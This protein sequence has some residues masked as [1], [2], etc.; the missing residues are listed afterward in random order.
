MPRGDGDQLH[1]NTRIL[2]ETADAG[3][4]LRR[5]FSDA[6]KKGAMPADCAAGAGT[7]TALANIP[8]PLGCGPLAPVPS[9][10]AHG[11]AR[12]RAGRASEGL[13]LD[14]VQRLIAA[15]RRASE[16]GRPFTHLITVHWEAA[17]LSDAEAMKATTAA[18]KYWREWLGGETAYIWTRENGGGKGTHLHVLAH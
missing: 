16:I 8:T 13:P 7:G 3:A 6:V 15:T 1:V 10:F 9:L 2:R 17:G 18:L 12:N 14:K 4:G 5:E 11:G